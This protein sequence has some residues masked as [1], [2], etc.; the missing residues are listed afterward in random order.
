[1]GQPRFA[2]TGSAELAALAAIVIA[3]AE[4]NSP[5]EGTVPLGLRS[6]PGATT[7][8]EKSFIDFLR[9]HQLAGFVHTSIDGTPAHDA[10]SPAARE[11][12]A[13]AYLQQ[14]ATNER[15]AAELRRLTRLLTTEDCP[16]LLLK[17][18]HLALSYYGGSDRRGFSD[19]DLLVHPADVERTLAV[20][21]DD[22]YRR[23]SRALFGQA[24]AARFTHACELTRQD[25]AVDL[26]WAFVR[27]PAYRIDYDAVWSRSRGLDAAGAAVKVLDDGYTLTFQC[28]AILKDLELGTLKLKSF[29]DLFFV[30]TTCEARLDWDR[31]VDTCERERTL[32]PVTAALSLL[33][34]LFESDERF[35]RL[36]Q[37]LPEVASTPAPQGIFS[38]LVAG[39][40]SATDRMWALRMQDP[41]MLRAAAWWAVSLPFR[42]A[43]HRPE[44]RVRAAA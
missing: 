37:S 30:T 9:R 4:G 2:A 13:G 21:E 22:G 34:R 24:L 14:W 10:L 12:L 6:T 31:F 5:V 28:L 44:L 40:R 16:F 7:F 41:S 25:T 32:R 43:A 1:M 19:L 36:G 38:R 26:H 35:P 20:L 42:I 8:D 27:H 33:L 3:N 11:R 39:R 18:L 17:G 29:V 15:L 23:R